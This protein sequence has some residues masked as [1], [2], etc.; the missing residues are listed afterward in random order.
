M[1]K[2]LFPTFLFAL[3]A[4]LIPI[5]IHLFNFRRY[6]TVYFSNVGFLKEIKKESKKKSKLKQLLILIA[7]LLTLFFLVFAFAQPYLPVHENEQ[8]QPNQV[9]GIY[10][11]NS[12]SM[13]ALSE[14]GRLLEVAQKK[15]LEIC[16]AFPARTKFRLFTNDLE[17]RHQHL[18]TKEQFIHQVSEIKQS[19]AVVPFSLI[20]NRFQ[21]QQIIEKDDETD[22]NLYIISD[23]QRKV[24]DLQTDT[25][26]NIF[27]YLIPLKANENANLY[28]DSCWVE[29]P[30]HRLNQA[31]NLL[32]RIKN[33]STQ[34]YQNLPLKLVVNDSVKSITNF[35]V[36][37]ENEM[38]A[39]LKYKNNTSGLHLGKIEITDYPFTHDN[40]WY[41]SY[42]V[43]TELKTLVI[44]ENT[45]SSLE[46]LDYI[47]AL[48]GNDDYVSLDKMNNQSL[49]I[50]KLKEYNTIILSNLNEFSSGFL[51][52]LLQLTQSGTTLVFFPELVDKNNIQNNTLLEKFGA[53]K[54]VSSDSVAQKIAGVDVD[55]SFYK[56]VFQK[57]EENPVLPEIKI[58]A[59]FQGNTRIPEISLLWFQN[60]SKA[61]SKLIIE[62]GNLWVFSFPLNQKNETFARDIIFV[63]TLYNIVLSSVSEQQISYTVG[64]TIFYDIP[65]FENLNLNSNIEIVNTESMESFVPEKT[66]TGNGTRI[67]F[68]DLV[69]EA[70]HYLVKND[71]KNITSLAFNYNR[72]ESVLSYFSVNE[73]KDYIENNNLNRTTVIENTT[74]NFTEIFDE[75]QNGKQLWRW[76]LFLALFFILAEV[77]ISRFMK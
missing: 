65:K 33:N 20:F 63:P 7:R 26:A 74:A 4:L 36:S 57:M 10:V 27:T 17:P 25:G 61:L 64:K 62:K 49:K 34:E 15:A 23:F 68:G 69:K 40:F 43:A 32:V 54:I 19:P 59:K 29:V 77:L 55:N 39:S 31:E 58:S 3:F 21:A 41:I 35:S 22:K 13:N 51:T 60:N 2:F 8:R 67:A 50:S 6:K 30:A 45:K 38:V 76:F 56:N 9:V 66:I 71:N 72:D 24:F 44:Y 5:F 16:F 73:L 42:F 14:Q 46:G 70:G 37:A 28:I 75:I 52:E 47:S 18:F 12:F 11:D 53:S 48:F 1:M